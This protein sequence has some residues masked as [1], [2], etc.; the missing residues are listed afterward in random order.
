MDIYHEL[1]SNVRGYC[2]SFPV[3]FTKAQNAILTDN[4][5]N[6]YIDFLGG[7]GTL[8]YGHN[9]PV[10]KKALLEYIESDSITHGLDMHTEAKTAF[11]QS[12][13]ERIL[14]PRKM[15]Y[16]VQF[17][18]PTG[19]NAVE[20]A[21]KIARKNTG[22]QTIVSFT[23]GFHGVTQGAAAVTANN[24]YKN[25]IGMPLPG[26]QFMPYDGYLGDFNTLHYFEKALQD[27][28]SGLGHPA[29]VI[30]ECIQGEGGLNSAS[31]AWM[32]GLQA[33]CKRYNMLL[34]VDDIQ[35]GCGRSGTF[36]SFEEFGIEPDVITLSK[37]LSGYGLPM[38]IVLLKEKLD[39]W[40]PG[41][42]NGTFRGNNHAFI[43]ARMA[44]E[45]YWADDSF[46]QSV[47]KK[48]QLIRSRLKEIQAEHGGQMKHKGRG[49]MQG[50]ECVN[51]QVASRITE[52]AFKRGLIIETSGSDG[53][54]VKILTPLTIEE[55]TLKAGLGIL[56]ECI[57]DVMAEQ[58]S[59]A[60]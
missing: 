5:G 41:E 25:A 13:N 18:G 44:L 36:F 46:S 58:I 3:T 43:T 49:I 31:A 9:N 37:S 2:R 59:K 48:A 60:S 54:V 51:G 21:L 16:K 8:N 38:A 45:T 14:K 26:V 28:S 22:R 7:A 53:Q 47:K 23:N 17:T 55:D 33:L 35:A 20:A 1:E 6:E 50:L 12:F 57:G 39:T 29:A 32:L 27:G 11:L 30:V 34:I 42:H 56:A 10:F 15:K 52:L 40:K 4:E 24:Y 19:T